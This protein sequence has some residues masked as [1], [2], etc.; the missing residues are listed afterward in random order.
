MRILRFVRFAGML[1]TEL[2]DDV[3]AADEIEAGRPEAI[4]NIG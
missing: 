2:N 1:R 3:P 4:T